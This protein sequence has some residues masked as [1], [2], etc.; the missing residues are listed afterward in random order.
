MSFRLLSTEPRGDPTPI[1]L[2]ERRR[3]VYDEL[4]QANLVSFL[5]GETGSFVIMF[6]VESLPDLS[7][8]WV[9]AMTGR[10]AHSPRYIAAAMADFDDLT[11]EPWELRMEAGLPV[12]GLLVLAHAH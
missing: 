4:T 10:Y 2:L 3:G 6:T 5:H 9:L 12:P 7:D 11:I 1:V 8:D